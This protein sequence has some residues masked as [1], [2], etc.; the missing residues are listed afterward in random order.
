MGPGGD[1]LTGLWS[2]LADEGLGLIGGV[3]FFGS[4]MLQAW[5]S[6]QVGSAVVSVRFFAIRASA[7]ALL[8]YEGLRSGSVSVFLVM[9][10]TGALM[11]Y[12]IWLS[13]RRPAT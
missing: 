11:L 12:N 8:A 9:A 10:A 5:E 2:T 13:T 6:R 1:I 7:S 3:L 4:W